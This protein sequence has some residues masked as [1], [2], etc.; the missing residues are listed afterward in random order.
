MTTRRCWEGGLPRKDLESSVPLPPCSALCISPIWVFKSGV[1]CNKLVMI[2]KPSSWI[3]WAILANYGAQEGLVEAP[4]REPAGR[5][6]RRS[7]ACYWP[8]KWGSL[9][10]WTLT[11]PVWSAVMPGGLR[12][13]LNY[14]APSWWQES[15]R[16]GW[17][18]RKP[19]HFRCQ[20]C[21]EIDL[22][23]YK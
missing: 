9:V 8:L 14:R 4:G 1:L 22:G 18:G 3:L 11:Y 21:C 5:K 19:V 12:T 20:G 10:G 13:E 23:W 17:C 6:Y 7:R 2:S 15:W 16:V